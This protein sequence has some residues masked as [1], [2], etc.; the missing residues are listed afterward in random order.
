LK[1]SILE[2]ESQRREGTKLHN[3]AKVNRKFLWSEA[4]NFTHNGQSLL[5]SDEFYWKNVLCHSTTARI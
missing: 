3:M 5:F 4:I 1:R 2:T